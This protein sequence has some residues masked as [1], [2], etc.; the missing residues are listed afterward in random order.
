[1]VKFSDVIKTSEASKYVCYWREVCGVKAA[2][3]YSR[4][5]VSCRTTI[6]L[7]CVESF[8]SDLWGTLVLCF[9]SFRVTFR[10]GLLFGRGKIQCWLFSFP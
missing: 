1:M 3:G 5:V 7:L 6:G 9:F 4:L 8:V 10:T 2:S